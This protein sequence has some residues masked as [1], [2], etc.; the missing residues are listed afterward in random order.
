MKMGRNSQWLMALL[1]ELGC[2]S[3]QYQQKFKIMKTPHI[4]LK[5]CR[6][7]EFS[8]TLFEILND[9]KAG[10]IVIII[11]PLQRMNWTSEKEF[12]KLTVII[13]TLTQ[14]FV[15]VLTKRV[16]LFPMCSTEQEGG[17]GCINIHV[18]NTQFIGMLHLWFSL[19]L[20]NTPTLTNNKEL[21]FIMSLLFYY[22]SYTSII[23]KCLQ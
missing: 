10:V 7:W 2:N 16:R 20:I 15:I 22:T 1:S 8:D 6:L 5:F 13:R 23:F 21:P 4:S 19:F 12:P 18:L 17:E 3:C 14:V 9:S 11:S